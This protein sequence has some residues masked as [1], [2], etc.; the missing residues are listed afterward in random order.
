[1]TQPDSDRKAMAIGVQGVIVIAIGAAFGASARE[2]LAMGLNPTFGAVGFPFGTLIANLAGAFALG[3]LARWAFNAKRHRLVRPFFESGVIRSFTTLSA[4]SLQ[5]VSFLKLQAWA[6]LG[7]YLS[8]TVLGGL[9]AVW[10]GS[11]LAGRLN[12]A[13]VAR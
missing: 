6:T 5:T 8:V 1:M 3:L 13:G 10:F 12:R 2:G 9:A 11:W 4:L 7:L